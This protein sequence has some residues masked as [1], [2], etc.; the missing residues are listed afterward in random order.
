MSFTLALRQD[1]ILVDVDGCDT[2]L[3]SSIAVQIR[4]IER[5]R[6]RE[7]EREMWP[8]HEVVFERMK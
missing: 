2:S 5:E 7:R 8:G 3:H 1:C 4:I 6:E